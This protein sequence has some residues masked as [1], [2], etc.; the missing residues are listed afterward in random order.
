[1]QLLHNGKNR[2]LTNVIFMTVGSIPGMGSIP[3][4]SGS[5]FFLMTEATMAAVVVG[6]CPV[7]YE[8]ARKSDPA[9]RGYPADCTTLAL[10]G[11]PSELTPTVTEVIFVRAWFFTIVLNARKPRKSNN[12]IQFFDLRGFRAFIAQ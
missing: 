10:P 9:T 6:S 5:L 7:Q 11:G 4:S 2:A 8:S 3:K 12:W 1:M